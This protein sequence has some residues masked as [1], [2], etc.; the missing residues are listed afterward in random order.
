MQ[1]NRESIDIQQEALVEK[2]VMCGNFTQYK[3]S[4]PI[5][6]RKYYIEGAGQLCEECY[7]NI[8]LKNKAVV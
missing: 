3:Y 6:L 4:T 7:N 1:K 2:C 5:F 8:Y